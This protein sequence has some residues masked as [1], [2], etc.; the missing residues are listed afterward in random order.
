MSEID[1]TN[2]R[3]TLDYIEYEVTTKG[4]PLES[5]LASLVATN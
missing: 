2:L 5:V 4:R 3:L 1:L